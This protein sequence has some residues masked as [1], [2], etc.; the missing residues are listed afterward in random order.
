[1]P[2][3][4]PASNSTSTAAWANC[5]RRINAVRTSKEKRMTD[6]KTLRGTNFTCVHAGPKERWTEFRLE[7]PDAPVPMQ[8]KLFLRNLLGSAGLEMSLN[9]IPPGKGMPFLHRHRQN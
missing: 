7:P 3:T 6:E 8:G 5:K 2:R 1:M 4:S 9:V